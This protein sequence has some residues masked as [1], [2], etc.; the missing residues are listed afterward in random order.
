M[1]GSRGLFSALE[2]TFL[3]TASAQPSS[4]RN[5]SA[6]AMRL[7][8][9]LWL[10]D[11]GEATQHQLQKSTLKMGKIEKIF[12]THTHGHTQIF[13]VSFL[14]KNIYFTGDHIFGLIPLMAH[15]LNGA[16][17]IAEGEDARL[18]VDLS[19]PVCLCDSQN[20]LILTTNCS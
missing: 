5:H 20:L 6:L 2:I 4:T 19:S 18:N 15:L 16:G 1:A 3:G 7:G 13:S 17:G 12:I 8:G 14:F 11:C 9:D 10:F